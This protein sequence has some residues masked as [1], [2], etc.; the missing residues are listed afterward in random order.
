MTWLT[1]LPVIQKQH[2]SIHATAIFKSLTVAAL[3][4]GVGAGAAFAAP[5]VSTTPSP[6]YTVYVTNQ[7]DNTISVIDSATRKVVDTFHLKAASKDKLAAMA[8]DGTL[9]AAHVMT[10]NDPV[11]D[12]QMMT[13]FGPH[14]VARSPEW[15]GGRF[16]A[17]RGGVSTKPCPG[18]YWLYTSNI[19]DGSVSFIDS[20]TGHGVKTIDTG[21][22]THGVTLSPDGRTVWV[23][24]KGDAVGVVDVDGK[25]PATLI[26]TPFNS[27]WVLFSEDGKHAYVN[28]KAC[29]EFTG[30]NGHGGKTCTYHVGI[31]D[32]ASRKLLEV[33]TAEK[34][35]KNEPVPAGATQV[36]SLENDHHYI[37]VVRHNGKDTVRFS[38][39][40]YYSHGAI[41]SPDGKQ[42]FVTTPGENMVTVVDAQSG[43]I[44]KKIKVSENPHIPAVS[45]DGKYVWV[46]CR[47]ANTVD[48]IDTRTLAVVASVPVG[49]RPHGITISP[50]S[51]SASL[52][53]RPEPPAILT[54]AAD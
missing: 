14:H 33:L 38:E 45:P 21:E 36:Y 32:V 53:V 4:L 7:A 10:A 50:G 13:D 20:E 41:P 23:A 51:A 30:P 8:H 19:V 2:L 22:R 25:S 26:P 3:T 6:D 24:N 37:S 18:P 1:A 31:I 39:I 11:M 9:H 52:V 49:E 48:I 35:V 46:V 44:I 40:E 29:S 28:G 54:L 27:N 15:C 42:V 16:D 5:A 34:G 43:A 47:G 17:M 12:V